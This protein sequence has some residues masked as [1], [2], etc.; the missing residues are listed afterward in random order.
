MWKEVVVIY[1]TS[2][3]RHLPGKTEENL[4]KPQSGYSM[5]RSR[6]EPV[7]LKIKF[8]IMVI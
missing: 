4:E 5:T 8:V 7:R 6:F 1:F 3:F 2:L